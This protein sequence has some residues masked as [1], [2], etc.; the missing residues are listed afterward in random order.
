MSVDS[1]RRPASAEP[2]IA[3]LARALARLARNAWPTLDPAARAEG[4]AAIA[5]FVAAPAPSSFL[6]AARRLVDVRR[7]R[8]A[9]ELSSALGE[10]VFARGAARLAAVPFLDDAT[11]ATLLAQ[12]HDGPAGRR[13]AALAALLEAHAEL[14]ARIRSADAGHIA[15][16]VAERER[17]RRR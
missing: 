7:Q 11:R 17:D 10:R 2:D 1:R 16:I 15:I 5:D 4:A 9:A 6:A 12:P 3:P 13:L 8:R 14:A